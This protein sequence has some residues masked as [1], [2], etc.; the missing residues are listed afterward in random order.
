MQP[1]PKILGKLHLCADCVKKETGCT[2]ASA[3]D[4]V[5]LSTIT[6]SVMVSIDVCKLG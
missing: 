3:A 1:Y 6:K 5:I 4:T 2:R